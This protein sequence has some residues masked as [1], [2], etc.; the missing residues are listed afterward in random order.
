[1]RVDAALGHMDA[2]PLG[3]RD[4]QLYHPNSRILDPFL[5]LVCPSSKASGRFCADKLKSVP[6]RPVSCDL[7]DRICQP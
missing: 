5:A 1:M 3:L 7:I 4:V 2:R 6:R